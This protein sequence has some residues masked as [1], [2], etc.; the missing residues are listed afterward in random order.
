MVVPKQ[1]ESLQEFNKANQLDPTNEE[2]Y[3]QYSQTMSYWRTTLIEEMITEAEERAESVS[4][5]G[6]PVAINLPRTALTLKPKAHGPYLI[7]PLPDVG[8]D[9]REATDIICLETQPLDVV[10]IAFESDILRVCIDV[11]GSE[12][13]WHISARVRCPITSS[14]S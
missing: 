10:I 5:P 11:E 13:R 12:P 1:L 9:C 7:R 4:L 8:M 3:G 6:E 14:F 2:G